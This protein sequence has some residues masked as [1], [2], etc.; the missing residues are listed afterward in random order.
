MAKILVKTP[1]TSNGRDVVVD[2]NNQVRYKE[3]IV[4]KGHPK[5]GPQ[6]VFEKMNRSLP[7]IRKFIIEPY[8]EPGDGSVE[9]PSI[10]G[11]P[12][13]GNTVKK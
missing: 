13:K 7:Q 5:T 1:I 8:N 2:A 4:E 9:A 6:A 3:T 10:S 12:N 11:K